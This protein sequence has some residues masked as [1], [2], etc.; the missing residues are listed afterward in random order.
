M[1]ER[2]NGSSLSRRAWL[3]AAVA[4]GATVFLGERWLRRANAEAVN[5]EVA[6][7]ATPI[8]VYASPTC[9]CCEKWVEHMRGAGFAPT[10][11]RIDDVSPVKRR[12][13]VPERLWSCHTAT[14]E[15]RAVEGHV[16]ADL[17]RRMLAEKEPIAGLAAPGMPNGSPGMEGLTK[18]TYEVIAFTA[19]GTARVYAVR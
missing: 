9:T 17:V 6:P 12:L 11:E 8:L 5:G 2:P 1:T 15:G 3:G 18:D 16:P 7:G 19:S 4:T 13:G 14:V 10:V